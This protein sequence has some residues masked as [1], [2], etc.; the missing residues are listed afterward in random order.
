MPTDTPEL[1][2]NTQLREKTQTGCGLV[3]YRRI[4]VEVAGFANISSSRNGLSMANWVPT[5]ETS[6]HAQD[7]VQA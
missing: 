7:R 1:K 4:I 6:D 2:V 5:K 3:F